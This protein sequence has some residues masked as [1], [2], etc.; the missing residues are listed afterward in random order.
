MSFRADKDGRVR[1]VPNPGRGGPPKLRVAATDLEHAIEALTRARDLL[2]L[3]SQATDKR[4]RASGLSMAREQLDLGMRFA[5]TV[6]R[7]ALAGVKK[8]K[9]AG[10]S[11]QLRLRLR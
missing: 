2:G 4:E 11:P 5:R 9:A 3:A 6:A 7:G 10:K 1:Y 8:P